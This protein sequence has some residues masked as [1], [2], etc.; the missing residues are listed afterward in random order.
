MTASMRVLLFQATDVRSASCTV[1]T[2]DVKTAFLNSHMKHEWQPE[3]LDP[4]KGTVIWKLQKSL[5]G[6]EKRDETLKGPSVADPQEMR[7]RPE[8][9]LVDSHDEVSITRIP[10]GRPVVA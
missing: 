3:T 1:F 10:R 4:S 8:H 9:F 2:A 7:L 6:L 5:Y